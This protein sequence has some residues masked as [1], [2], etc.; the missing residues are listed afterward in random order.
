MRIIFL[1]IAVALAGSS[2]M[3]HNPLTAKFE[4]KA[5]PQ[6]GAILNIYLSQVGLHQALTTHFQDTDFTTISST[7]YKQLA[8]QYIKEKTHL[9]ADGRPL[10]I[11]EGGIKLGHHQTDLKLAIEQYPNVVKQLEI[12]V[13]CFSEN[14][15]HHSVFWWKTPGRQ[16][17]VVLSKRNHYQATLGTKDEQPMVAAFF[18]PFPLTISWVLLVVFLLGGSSFIYNRKKNLG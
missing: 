18:S 2:A 6:G 7:A 8:V 16:A 10:L 4:L 15:N 5:L 12:K 17:K 3:A 9:R 11:G 14:G 13:D 1:I